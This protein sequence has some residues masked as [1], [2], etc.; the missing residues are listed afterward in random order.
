M[1]GGGDKKKRMVFR[2]RNNIRQIF[3]LI[4]RRI[5]HSKRFF[6]GVSTFCSAVIAGDAGDGFFFI[7]R[8]MKSIAGRLLP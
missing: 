3:I 2:L 7:A 1:D 5:F 6:I 4:F 8:C